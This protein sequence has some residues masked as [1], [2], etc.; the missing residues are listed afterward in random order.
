MWRLWLDVAVKGG[1]EDEP[2]YSIEWAAL[3]VARSHAHPS[4]RG[5]D[6]ADVLQAILTIRREMNMDSFELLKRL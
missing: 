2:H 5:E 6:P 4:Y 3:E 1:T